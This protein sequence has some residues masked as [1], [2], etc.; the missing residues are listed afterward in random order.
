MILLCTFAH[1][2]HMYFA[3]KYWIFST[4][5]AEVEAP[6]VP[7]FSKKMY[8]YSQISG[9]QNYMMIYIKRKL[10]MCCCIW[11][12]P[13]PPRTLKI[14]M[15]SQDSS[16]FEPKSMES[17]NLL[18]LQIATIFNWEILVLLALYLSDN[19]G[20]LSFLKGENILK[21]DLDL[22]SICIFGFIEVSWMEVVLKNLFVSGASVVYLDFSRELDQLLA[23]QRQAVIVNK[24]TIFNKNLNN[25]FNKIIRH[26]EMSQ[27]SNNI[28]KYILEGLLQISVYKK[29][30]AKGNW[31]LPKILITL[32][33][34]S[35]ATKCKS[36]YGQQSLQKKKKLAQLHAVD[37]QKFLGSFCCYSN[38]SP[39][40]IEPSFDAQSLCILQSDCAKKIYICKHVELG[41][42]LGWSMPHVN[43]RQTDLKGSALLPLWL[44]LSSFQLQSY[45]LSATIELYPFYFRHKR[46][47]NPPFY[48]PDIIIPAISY[49]LLL[50]EHLKTPVLHDPIRKNHPFYPVLG[51][52][53]HLK[54]PC[55]QAS[56]NIFLF[57]VNFCGPF[58]SYFPAPGRNH[59]GCKKIYITWQA[60]KNIRI[61]SEK[62]SAILIRSGGWDGATRFDS[63]SVAHA[64]LCY[65]LVTHFGTCQGCPQLGDYLEHLHLCTSPSR[66]EANRILHPTIIFTLEDWGFCLIQ[67][68]LFPLGKIGLLQV[69]D[70]V[71]A[72]ELRVGGRVVGTNPHLEA[73]LLLV[74]HLEA[75]LS[76]LVW[77]AH[78]HCHPGLILLA[79]L[80]QGRTSG[81]KITLDI[82]IDT[83]E[84][85]KMFSLFVSF[86]M[87]S[88]P[89]LVASGLTSF[90]IPAVMDF[91]VY[92]KSANS[93]LWEFFLLIGSSL[94]CCK[95]LG[96]GRH[97]DVPASY[98]WVQGRMN[99]WKLVYITLFIFQL[100]SSSCLN[101]VF[102]TQFLSLSCINPIV[103]W[104]FSGLPHC[105]FFL[106]F[107][108][109]SVLSHVISLP[110]F[111]SQSL[112]QTLKKN[113]FH[114]LQW[115]CSMLEPSCHPNTTCLHVK[116]FRP[117]HCAVT[118]ETVH[119]SLA[120]LD[121]LHIN[122]RQLSKFF[123]FFAVFVFDF[124]QEK[125]K[126]KK[127][128]KKKKKKERKKERKKRKK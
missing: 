59:L 65:D 120:L 18:S 8:K 23:I 83:S 5:A 82:F 91:M 100:V 13:T 109:Y 11:A 113:S 71:G 98:L 80:V 106:F 122:C 119:Q 35:K 90:T 96:T 44:Y 84:A 1:P 66:V 95:T 78:H 88:R 41:W 69:F 4:I 2:P 25:Y 38:H 19:F 81:V 3:C 107:L 124:N 30:L 105:F 10:N 123:F 97:G 26:I 57:S 85:P 111:V 74:S 28:T 94:C 63:M 20:L 21:L 37:M 72:L 103:Y 76:N 116:I 39:K 7:S 31:K 112:L 32:N 128:R 101:L 121:F 92:K 15:L 99:S 73:Q 118:T 17:L 50:P 102:L 14:D 33:Q 22:I 45:S 34:A 70:G 61:K 75:W 125:K 53:G 54:H 89:K 58:K 42:Q 40:L 47:S 49:P 27:Q 6:A 36:S 52:R 79:T 115:K 93:P 60:I 43:C 104:C 67:H 108:L 29:L 110:L 9:N 16:A 46:P 77:E 126:K 55:L 56:L 87:V 24:I 62:P 127:K 86:S 48:P 12:L 68:T 64:A 51:Y 117:S 114:C